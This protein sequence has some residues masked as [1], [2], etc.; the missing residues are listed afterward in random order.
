MLVLLSGRSFSDHRAGRQSLNLE[1]YQK[2]PGGGSLL[3]GDRAGSANGDSILSGMFT[4]QKRSESRLSDRSQRKPMQA[5]LFVK[6][7][8]NQG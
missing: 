7:F 4:T 3:G 5:R 6:C 2:R 1:G 8:G